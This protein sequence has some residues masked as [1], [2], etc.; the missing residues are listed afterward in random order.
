MYERHGMLIVEVN[1]LTDE[2]C[3]GR[4]TYRQRCAN[5]EPDLEIVAWRF[6]REAGCGSNFGLSGL[7]TRCP[8]RMLEETILGAGAV[9][10]DAYMD[11]MRTWVLCSM[12]AYTIVHGQN[13]LPRR[14]MLL[15]VFFSTSPC[16]SCST[17][18]LLASSRLRARSSVLS[19]LARLL[20]LPKT[21][22]DS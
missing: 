19:V 11:T 8:L 4:A 14:F 9:V 3:S 20:T 17:C 18:N 15:G 16:F 5:D 12:Y 1:D 7:R 22:S 13:I 6:M 2:V 10:D 21:W